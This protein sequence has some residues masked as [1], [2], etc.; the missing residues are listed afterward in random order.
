MNTYI[1]VLSVIFYIL[2]NIW[3]QVFL[4]ITWKVHSD[5]VN[6][7]IIQCHLGL[8]NINKRVTWSGKMSWFQ[9]LK[10][11]QVG[12]K[13]ILLHLGDYAKT[14]SGQ[15]CHLYPHQGSSLLYCFSFNSKVRLIHSM[16]WY[17]KDTKIFSWNDHCKLWCG[18]LKVCPA[19]NFQNTTMNLV[20]DI[21]FWI[22]VDI[23]ISN[24][25]IALWEF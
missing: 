2:K 16:A 17:F 12:I 25:D 23:P 11:N 7:F 9:K 22:E 21:F 6:S 14:S 20:R 10:D 8:W 3:G 18:L 4:R 19:L 15:S 24:W 13:V 1:L 5:M